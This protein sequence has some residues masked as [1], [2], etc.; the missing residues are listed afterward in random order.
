[1]KTA[2]KFGIQSQ[3]LRK[4]IKKWNKL[5]HSPL[6]L[7]QLNTGRSAKYPLLETGLIS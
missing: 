1:M 6:Y 4:W 5:M 7:K 2:E 3:Q